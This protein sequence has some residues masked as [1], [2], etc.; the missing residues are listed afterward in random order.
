[1]PTTGMT[2]EALRRIYLQAGGNLSAAARALG[3][4]RQAMHEAVGRANRTAPLNGDDLS[5]ADRDALHSYLSSCLSR[6]GAL[7]YDR[8]GTGGNIRRGSWH[9]DLIAL[10]LGPAPAPRGED[11]EKDVSN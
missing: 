3:I 4:S 5:S 2:A 9:E 6:V 1:M 8:N 7:T 10:L 11:A